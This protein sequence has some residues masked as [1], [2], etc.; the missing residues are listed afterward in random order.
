V[1]VDG[2]EDGED[3]ASEMATED[4]ERITLPKEDERII[5]IVDP[6][7]PSQEEVDR[8]YLMGHLPYRNWCAVCVRAK[9]KERSHKVDDNR[10]RKVPEY[11][12]DYCFRGYEMGFKWT[13]LVG[14]ERG[15][16]SWMA[17]AVPMKGLG[18]GQFAT[19]K[20]VEF[21]EE[22]GDKDSTVIV[23]TDQEPSMQ[24]LAQDV[25]NKRLEGQTIL[26]E[27][28]KKSSGSNGIVE[29]GVQEI[30]GQMRAILLDTVR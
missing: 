26:E 29:R 1:K 16:K 27:S 23:K 22:N 11:S 13:V 6:K 21:M 24:L 2:I 10:E 7:L 12:F 3:V 28:P 19:D 18:P 15:T 4:C 8:H 20:C 30:E 9:G 14:K 5:K 17:T 25:I